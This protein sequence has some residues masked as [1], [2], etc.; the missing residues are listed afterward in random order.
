[1]AVEIIEKILKEGEKHADEL[2][3]FFVS[4]TS[5]SADLRKRTLSH[6]H[7]SRGCGLGVRIIREGRIG[8][9][10]T[11]DPARWRECLEA[12]IASGR[13]ATPQAWGGLPDPA[14]LDTADLAFDSR[15]SIDA[16]I[17]ERLLNRMIDGV[18]RYKGAEVTSGTASLSTSSA[19][20][21]NSRG[22]RYSCRKTDVSISIEAICGQSTGFE[23]E[24]ACGPEV[25]PVA[26]GER[27]AFLATHSAHGKEIATGE[28]D[29]VFS[30]L[31]F[32]QILGQVI[33]PALSGRNVHAGRSFLAP[34]L[35]QQIFDRSIS[36]YDDPHIPQ[37][38]GSTRW[39]AEGVP[40]R[41]LDFISEG[42]LNNFAYDLKTGYR[43][44]MESTGSAV[45]G[46][47]GGAPSIGTHNLVVDGPR[48]DIRDERAVYVENLIGAHTANP[49]SGDFSVELTN[50]IWVDEK[51]YGDPIRKAM[52]AGN[53][54]SLLKGIGG[55]GRDT[56]TLGSMRLP[57][58]RL[59]KQH[60]IGE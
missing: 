56:R 42:V 20:L 17:A 41:R 35:G 3:V 22:V 51:E 46:G 49:M 37:G 53:V 57:S 27:A 54:F 19:A 33:V 55:L 2:E 7:E 13:L 31:A 40:T 23:F 28:Y 58:I 11:N 47:Y 10:G 18:N 9:S 26:V 14:P 6:A 24:S 8:A 4:A 38:L 5:L 1:V 60:I 16:G 59:N 45:R 39:D 34:L 36:L 44:G 52:L 15:V 50:P 43:Y 25:D 48:S 21:A 12:A 30:P 32:A 29:V